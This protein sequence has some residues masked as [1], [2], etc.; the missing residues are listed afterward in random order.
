M[1]YWDGVWTRAASKGIFHAMHSVASRHSEGL[2]E[3]HLLPHLPAVGTICELGSGSGLNSLYLA[4]KFPGSVVTLVDT[5]AP[6]LES[7][8]ASFERV[9]VQVDLK[10]VDLFTLD[11]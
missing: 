11:D 8:R 4:R 9:G 3:T 1:S 7:A 10:N 5:S 2:L 6:V